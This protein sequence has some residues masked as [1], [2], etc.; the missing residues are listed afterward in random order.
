MDLSICRTSRDGS[1]QLAVACDV[2][3][4]LTI[5]G[6]RIYKDLDIYNIYYGFDSE[7][8]EEEDHGC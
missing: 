3:W 4:W 5:A 7:N 6:V 8:E 1:Q 2:S